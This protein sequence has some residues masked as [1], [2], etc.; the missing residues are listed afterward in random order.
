MHVHGRLG[1]RQSCAQRDDAGDVHRFGGLADT[2]ED[3]FIHQHGVNAS[4][5]EQRRDSVTSEFNRIEMREI[6]A[7]ARKRRA[8]GGD[9]NK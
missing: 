7:S 2:A 3:G 4:A 6:G 8:R 1:F 9:N 5:R